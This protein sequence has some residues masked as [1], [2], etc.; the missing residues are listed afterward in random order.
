MFF[1]RF[2][3]PM[4]LENISI[5]F[6]VFARGRKNIRTLSDT[7]KL[8]NSELLYYNKDSDEELNRFYYEFYH[9]L[10]TFYYVDTRI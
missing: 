1:N 7:C 9:L 6:F 4:L 10:N 3:Q 5:A 2:V 8:T